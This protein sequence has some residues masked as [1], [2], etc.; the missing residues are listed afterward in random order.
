MPLL[1]QLLVER[2]AEAF[3]VGIQAAQCVDH[4]CEQVSNED[5]EA[6][7]YELLKAIE[8]WTPVANGEGG[9]DA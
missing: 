5:G 9:H 6:A 8:A 4:L 1:S 2:G 3:P 7:Y